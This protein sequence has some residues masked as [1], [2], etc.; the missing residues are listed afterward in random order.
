MLILAFGAGGLTGM[1]VEEGLGLDWF[2]FLDED[3]G[4]VDNQIL[5]GLQIS[6]DQ[7]DRI[8]EILD[9]QERSLEEY[10]ESHIPDM[11]AIVSVSYGRVRE[12]LTSE[13]REI[14]DR[15]ISEQGIPIPQEPD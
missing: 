10:W 4:E 11:R 3:T 9:A 14:F 8:E 13:Q 5:A 7:R 12:V 6:E 2:D 1:A 15:R